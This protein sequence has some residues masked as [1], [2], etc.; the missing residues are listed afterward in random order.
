LEEANIKLE[1]VLSDIMGSTGRA[2]IQALIDGET[3]P[4]KL[5]ALAHPKVRVSEATLREAL[6]GR[7]KRHHRFLLRLHRSR[8]TPSKPASPKSTGRSTLG[9]APF[10]TL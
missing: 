1:S 4:A 6:R 7:V 9:S 8:S 10:A 3:E 2:M 5:A